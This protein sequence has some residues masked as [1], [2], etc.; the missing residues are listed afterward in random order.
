M[1]DSIST[2]EHVFQSPRWRLIDQR[3]PRDAAIT[4]LRASLARER[5]S[6]REKSDQLRR[7]DLLVQE[8][9]HRLLNGLQLVISLLS[10]QSRAAEPAAASQLATAARRIATFARLHRHLHTRDHQETV[11]LKDYL[12]Q[13]CKGLSDLLLW[14]QAGYAVVVE[15]VKLEVSTAFAIPLGFIANEMITNSAKYAR[16]NIIVR[17]ETTPNVGHSLSVLDEGPGLPPDF[18]PTKSNGLGM[19]IMLS[20]VEQIG[21]VLQIA[22]GDNGRGTR[23]V[24]TFGAPGIPAGN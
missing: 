3:K 6:L 7:Q 5:A 19:K 9:E 18:N 1:T 2:R 11:E 10:L 21:G 14:E 20:F 4:R 12:L 15:G 13:L 17:L 22:P 23:F 16:G 8:F 24:V